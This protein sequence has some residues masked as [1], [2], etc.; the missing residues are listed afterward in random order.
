AVA[1]LGQLRDPKVPLL[2]LAGSKSYG[3]NLR[4]LVIDALLRRDAWA[5]TLL[6]AVEKK[7]VLA[8]DLDAPRRQRFLQHKDAGLRARAVKLFAGAVNPDRQK[9][10]DAYQGVLKIQGDSMRGALVF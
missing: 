4:G 7:D 9:V 2:L 3:P 10:I 1:A 8:G 5:K 6:D